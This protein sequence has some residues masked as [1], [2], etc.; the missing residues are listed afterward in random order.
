MYF[1]RGPLK[2]SG[3]TMQI[4]EQPSRQ[5]S[6]Q[7]YLVAKHIFELATVLWPEKLGILV[8]RWCALTERTE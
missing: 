4:R 2:C 6:F 1:I 5:Q 8:D 3:I 7:C